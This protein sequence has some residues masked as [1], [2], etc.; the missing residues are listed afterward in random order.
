MTVPAP[1]ARPSP[2]PLIVQSD[3]SIVLEVDQP[4]FA[5]ARDFLAVFAELEKAPEHV[6]FYRVTPISIWNAAA[7][8]LHAEPLLDGLAARSRF[9][10][11]P[12]LESEIR[13]WF[14]RYGLLRLERGEGALTLTSSEP[15]LL[16]ELARARDVAPLVQVANGVLR[17]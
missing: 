2:P 17:V 5:E 12:S 3:R 8:G 7:A 16:G 14:R 15:D 9:P 10:V 13:D 4:G 1:A 11:P 6:H